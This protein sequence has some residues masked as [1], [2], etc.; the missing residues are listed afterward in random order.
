MRR[1]NKNM[2]LNG[3]T[4]FLLNSKLLTTKLQIRFQKYF[5]GMKVI[6]SDEQNS[7]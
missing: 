7:T 4:S 1:I 3:V 6:S 2:H 5:D